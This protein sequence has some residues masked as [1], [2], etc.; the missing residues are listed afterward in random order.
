MNPKKTALYD[1]HITLGGQMVQFA[2][3]WL[4]V[5][6]HSEKEEHLAVRHHVGM[7]DVSHMGK[8]F[9][10]GKNATHF[11]QRILTNNIEK[12]SLGQ[13]QYTLLLNEHGGIIDDLIV[14]RLEKERFL[15][16]VNAANIERDWHYLL[17]LSSDITN[18]CRE[19]VSHLYSLIA[20]QGPKALPLLH[21]LAKDH[22]LPERFFINKI[23]LLGIKTCVS[24]TGYTNGDGFEIFVL[25]ED[26]LALWHMLYQ[27]GQTYNLKPCGLS[28][29]DSLRIEGGLL[30]HG[31]DMNESITPLEAG[32]MYAVA[33][34]KTQ[35]IGKEA[36]TKQKTEG[37]QKKLIG[38]TLTERGIA[39]QGFKILDKTRTEIGVVTSGTFL[40]EPEISIGLGYVH[41]D[42]A[43]LGEDVFIDIRGR[44][45][46]AALCIPRFIEREKK[47]G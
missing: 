20:V 45:T 27:C 17:E 12:L 44:I 22:V 24:R 19:N 35:F 38:F 40:S 43:H 47:N 21:E 8:F 14:Y 18:G 15:L 39:R 7:F 33:M 36:L 6:Y 31:Q 28:A 5:R 32:L 37:C 10:T 34:N 13:A 25:N 29:R 1:S 9:I 42:H 30:L 26:A 46:K 2:G 4:P 3:T 41:R 11:L 16:V 23:N